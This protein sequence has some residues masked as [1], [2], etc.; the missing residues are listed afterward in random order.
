MRTA[1]TIFSGQFYAFQ[2]RSPGRGETVVVPDKG[3][4]NFIKPSGLDRI[5]FD[6]DP[7]FEKKFEAYTTDPAAAL[8]LLDA[9]VR[10][11]L[12]ELRA[13]GRVAAFFGPEDVLVGTWGKNRFEPGSMFSSRPAEARARGMFDEVCAALSVTRALKAAL[14]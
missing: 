1:Q 11:R 2:R 4:F 7:E 13:I 9:D 3:I 14:D 10:R 8:S 12:V 6:G 5:R